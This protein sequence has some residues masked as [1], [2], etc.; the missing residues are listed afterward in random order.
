MP[1]EPSGWRSACTSCALLAGLVASVE[2]LASLDESV[3]GTRRERLALSMQS[4]ASYMTRLF[5]YLLISLK[6]LPLIMV[7]GKSTRFQFPC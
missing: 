2:Y 3:T 5:D 4:A 6:S 1:P 7:I